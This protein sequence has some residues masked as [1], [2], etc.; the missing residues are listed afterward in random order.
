MCKKYT[1]EF[2]EDDVQNMKLYIDDEL[3]PIDF[4]KLTYHTDTDSKQGIK[5]AVF[6]YFDG[7]TPKIDVL[8]N[9]LGILDV[10]PSD[11]E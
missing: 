2:F 3:V 8:G 1:I 11:L 9:P 4:M 7:Q 10:I 5:K 6:R